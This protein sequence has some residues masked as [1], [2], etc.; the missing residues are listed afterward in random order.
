[1]LALWLYFAVGHYTLVADTSGYHRTL[2]L[3]LTNC[4]ITPILELTALIPALQIL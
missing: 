3:A 2:T 1:M 4:K